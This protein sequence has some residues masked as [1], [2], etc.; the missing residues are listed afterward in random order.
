M[1]VRNLLLALPVLVCILGI[2][3]L[4][5]AS[6]PQEDPA[7]TTEQALLLALED[8]R[9]AE[10]IYRAVLARH[11]DVRP[12]AHIVQAEVR[13]QQ[14][15]L[16]LLGSYAIAVPD[17]PW[18]GDAGKEIPVADTL[19]DACREAMEAEKAN[20][21][22]YDDLLAE[23]EDSQVRQ[24]FERL[25]SASQDHHLRAFERC[26]EGRMGPGRGMGRGQ[27]RA[28]MGGGGCGGDCPCSRG[29]GG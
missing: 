16:N 3:V 7:T 21:A 25:Q 1:R 23:L 11:G 12:F 18:A 10:A 17:N 19:K 28:G 15:L 22:L 29:A 2:A 27:G 4:A 8:E 5:Q 9:H 24:V 6:A 26:A 20:I 13:H 14:Y